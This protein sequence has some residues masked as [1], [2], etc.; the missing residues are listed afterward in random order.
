MVSTGRRLNRVALDSMLLGAAMMLS[1]LEAVLP[2]SFVVPI[3]GVKLGLANLAVMIVFFECGP[4]DAF[5]VSSARVL[6]S[7]L[8]FGSP[9]SLAISGAGAAS[10]YIGL[11]V[12]KYLLS[13]FLSVLSASVI[14]AAL[15]ALGQLA[16]ASF[17]VS[18]L[19]VFSYSPVM[20]ISSVLT[21]ALNGY[22][23]ILVL[24][25]LFKLEG[26]LHA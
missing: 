8:L 20:L 22:I 10:A 18:D 2:L 19:S 26:N 25:K 4:I 24:K 6:L 17:T 11:V 12:Y 14:S 1:Y 7:G 5:A 21:G 9:V 3:P 23:C 16:A 15:H 13:G